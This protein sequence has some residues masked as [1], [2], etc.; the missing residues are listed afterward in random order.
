MENEPQNNA[1]VISEISLSELASIRKWTYFLAIIGFVASAFMILFGLFF[2]V[3]SKFIPQ[4]G[5]ANKFPGVLIMLFYFIIGLIY[6]FPS[7]FLFNFSSKIKTALAMHSESAF[8]EALNY[9]RLHFKFM[10][11][12]VIVG[13]GLVILGIVVAIALALIAARIAR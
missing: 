4:E 13:I 8:A 1:L 12:M 6:I 2:G 3:M 5:A 7:L 10:G 9:L 11:I